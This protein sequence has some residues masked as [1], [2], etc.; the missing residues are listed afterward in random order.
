MA[1]ILFDNNDTNSN[2]LSLHLKEDDYIVHEMADT[3]D[4]HQNLRH[5]MCDNCI[6]KILNPN[7]KIPDQIANGTWIWG[8]A[9]TK[10]STEWKNLCF[11]SEINQK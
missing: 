9:S 4:T 8:L 11:C 7:P 10:L 2:C 1:E 6:D 3:P 5:N